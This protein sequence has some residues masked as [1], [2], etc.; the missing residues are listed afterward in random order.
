MISND[1]KSGHTS[2]FYK[3]KENN[4]YVQVCTISKFKRLSLK[5]KFGHGIQIY[6]NMTF[7]VK[8]CY[9][10]KILGSKRLSNKITSLFTKD[11]LIAIPKG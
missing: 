6:Q 9:G 10:Q 2:K 7:C 5:R 8:V 1:K 3:K 4:L 11:M